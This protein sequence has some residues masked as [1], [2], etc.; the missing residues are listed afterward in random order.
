MRSLTQA[1][2]VREHLS[3]KGIR[4]RLVRTPGAAAKGG[5]GYSLEITDGL[6]RAR[7][8]VKEFLSKSGD[9]S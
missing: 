2:E 3:A 9:S 5:C 7:Q 4:S 6:A 8:I 1:L